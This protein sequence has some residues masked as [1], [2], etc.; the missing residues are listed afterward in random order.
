MKKIYLHIGPPKTGSTFLQV[1]LAKAAPGLQRLGV[2]YPE[3]MRVW[4]G[5][6]YNLRKSSVTHLRVSPLVSHE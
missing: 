6:A 3:T 4:R 5:D 1:A 2:L